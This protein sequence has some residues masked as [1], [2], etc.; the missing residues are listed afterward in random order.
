MDP[1]G[2]VLVEPQFTGECIR[3]AE[4]DMGQ[5]ARGKFDLDLVGHYARPDIFKLI[6]NENAQRV[7]EQNDGGNAQK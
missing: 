6:V 5:I 7:V 1:L 4:L 3:F 2:N